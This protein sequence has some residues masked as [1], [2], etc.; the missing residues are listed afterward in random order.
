MAKVAGTSTKTRFSDS[1]DAETPSPALVPS[2]AVP[3]KAFDF[4]VWLILV[5]ATL[6]IYSQ[7]RHFDFVYWDD[8]RYVYENPHV[9]AG[10]TRESV[11]WAWTAVVAAEWAP[12]SLMSHLLASQ[13]FAMNSG[14]HHLVNVALQALAAIL[15][16]AAFRRATGA[17][18][19]SAFVALL[20]AVHPLHVESVAWI[21]ERKDVLSAVFWFLGFYFYVRYAERPSPGR[22]ALVFVSFCLGL[23]SKAMIVTF[24]F[25]LFLLDIW[26][27]HRPRWRQNL[28]EKLVLIVLSAATA[29][30]TYQIEKSMGGVQPFLLWHRMAR[31]FTSYVTYIG[32]MFWP[33]RLACFYPAASAISRWASVLAMIAILGASALAIS[34]WRRRPY[35][36]TGWFWYLGTLVPVIGFVQVGV[37][38]HADRYMYIPMVGLSVILAWGAAD[39]VAKWPRTK[40]PLLSLAG[41]SLVACMALAA[42]QTA[43]W[44]NTETLYQQAI[45]VTQ[46]NFVAEFNLGT[47]LGK[48]QR[49]FEAIPHLAAASRIQPNHALAQNNLGSAL[50]GIGDCPEAEPHF[51]RALSLKPDYPGVHASIG[52]CEMK[53]EHFAEAIAQFEAEVRVTPDSPFS[54]FDLGVALSMIP[55]RAS[56]GIKQYEDT[57][58]VSPEDWTA[59]V[60]LG[61]LLVGLGRRG[62]GIEHL[63]A[64]ERIHPDPALSKILANLRL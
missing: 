6:T 28:W 7:V 36:M 13:L 47:W 11:R 37:Q 16:Y 10:L 19:R 8:D 63:E 59:H 56:A 64:A 61:G 55:E 26:P 58:R 41:V 12:L 29:I 14:D 60:S 39:V 2:Q 44:E 17:R 53:R 4:I 45:D 30:A 33:T 62:E 21:A 52:S 51:E 42:A 38:A 40:R 35:L 24:P 27:L 49:P 32:Q 57:L 23:L 43:H 48:N 9:Q 34:A 46:N 18:W 54:H 25:T 3:A 50:V 1:R 15:L 20:F 22:Y 5:L 31:A